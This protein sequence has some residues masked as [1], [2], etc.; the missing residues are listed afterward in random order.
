SARTDSSVGPSVNVPSDGWG[1]R[2]LCC[3]FGFLTALGV[4]RAFLEGLLP[5][6]PVAEAERPLVLWRGD[7]GAAFFAV[8]FFAV[9]FFAV[10]FFA[11]AFFAV[12]FFAEG[13]LLPCSLVRDLLAIF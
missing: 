4:F 1:E 11:V 10:A 3:P 7:L 5:L 8:A 9:A 12:A 6:R 13:F 2:G